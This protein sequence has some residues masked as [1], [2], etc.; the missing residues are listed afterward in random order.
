MRNQWFIVILKKKVPHILWD[1]GSN[2][3][4]E[5]MQRTYDSA[6]YLYYC[7]SL[8]ELTGKTSTVS[9]VTNLELQIDS[10]KARIN[11]LNKAIK[12]ALIAKPM[13]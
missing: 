3:V 13:S 10:N 2:W 6:G 9:R 7:T 5:I 8:E 12:N 1:Y 4:A 11:A